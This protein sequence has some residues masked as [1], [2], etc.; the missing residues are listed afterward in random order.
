MKRLYSI[1]LA[2]L[3]GMCV[4]LPARAKHPVEIP[5]YFSGLA[6]NEGKAD[7]VETA[8]AMVAD[9]PGSS[10]VDPVDPNLAK[11]ELTGSTLVVHEY[12]EGSVEISIR[13]YEFGDIILYTRFDHSLTIHLTD[14]AIY[15]ITMRFEDRR[16]A[17]GVFSYP[18]SYG[19]KQMKNGQLYIR[20]GSSIYTLPGTKVK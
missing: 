17:Y 1:I 13:N 10:T 16:T 3:C 11:A 6:S 19:K 4:A 18:V 5:L 9:S 20:R 7:S 15:F 14:A 12:V 2:I 8:I